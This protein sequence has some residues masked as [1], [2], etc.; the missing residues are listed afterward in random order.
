MGLPLSAI[1]SRYQGVTNPLVA[2]TGNILH[3][4]V[5]INVRLIQLPFTSHTKA[6]LV[7]F[8]RFLGSPGNNSHILSCLQINIVII[9][10]NV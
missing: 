1:P 5:T 9:G 8:L 10:L 2:S 6:G 4:I 7:G 3:I